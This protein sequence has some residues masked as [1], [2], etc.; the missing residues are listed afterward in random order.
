[1]SIGKLL[2]IGF[3]LRLSAKDVDTLLEQ[4]Y[5]SQSPL[6][7]PLCRSHKEFLLVPKLVDNGHPYHPIG[8]PL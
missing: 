3:W 6:L 4:L 2:Y 1:M 8:T 5:H 7:K